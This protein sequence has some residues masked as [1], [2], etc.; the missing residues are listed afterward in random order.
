MINAAKLIQGLFFVNPAAV[1][2]VYR[3]TEPQYQAAEQVKDTETEV[4]YGAYCKPIHCRIPKWASNHDD[5]GA[6]VTFS[7]RSGRF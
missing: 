4:L 2:A 3:A 1:K 5:L 6:S 7:S